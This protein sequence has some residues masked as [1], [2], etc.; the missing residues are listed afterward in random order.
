MH[1]FS[2]LLIRK[3][4]LSNR[5]VMTAWPSG[6]ASVDGVANSALSRYYV[7][8]AR[9]GAGV[10]VLESAYPIAPASPTPHLGLYDDTFVA[11][12]RACIAS[13]HQHNAVALIM[14][15]QPLPTEQMTVAELRD[16]SDAWVTAAWRARSAG[17]NGIMFSCAD[18]GPFRQLLSPLTNR[19]QDIY[20][21]SLTQRTKL[22]LDTVDQV[23]NLMGQKILFGLRLNVE[24]FM[25][26]GL[27][28]QDARVVARRLSNAG[29]NLIEVSADVSGP[30]PLA[31]FPGWLTPLASAIKI[32]VD[33]P[34]MVGGQLDDPDLANSVIRDRSA[35]LV[36]LGDVLAENAQWPSFARAA[37]G[38]SPSG[39][40]TE[41]RR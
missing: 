9:G 29:V 39:A 1:L 15:D 24:E 12:L 41:D 25:P 31:Q 7:E 40:A 23:H 6:C 36:A 26:G 11:D 20:G 3:T 32:V 2:P 30:A 28:L 13:I 34:V 4:R 33:V 27:T 21:G 8:R 16:V 19:R 5:I 22:L 10:V 38:L 14:I 35:D 18:H 17:A 37:L